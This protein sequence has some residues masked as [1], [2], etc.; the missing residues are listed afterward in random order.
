MYGLSGFVENLNFLDCVKP[1][2]NFIHYMYKLFG[3]TERL[4][5]ANTLNVQN[6][7]NPTGNC[8]N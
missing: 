5:F 1:R 4:K 2:G 8:V 6:C 3:F 7:V